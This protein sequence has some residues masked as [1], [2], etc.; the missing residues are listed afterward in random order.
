MDFFSTTCN[1]AF[2]TLSDEQLVQ[3]SKAGED[4]AFNLLYARYLPKIRSMVY[5]FQGLGFDLEDLMQEAT[6]GFFSAID[7]YDGSVSAFS[8]FCY[9]CMRRMM[10]SLLRSGRKKTAVPRDCMIYELDD[11]AGSAASEPEFCYIAKES[12]AVLKQQLEQCLSHYEKAVLSAFLRGMD[13]ENIANS[14]GKSVKSVDNALQRVRAKLR[15][16]CE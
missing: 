16:L 11:I 14:L 7:A 1:K 9:V 8:T 6:I 10:L 2:T 13:Y 5:P 12:Y 4:S 15:F 3:L